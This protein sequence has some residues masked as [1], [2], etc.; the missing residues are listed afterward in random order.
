MGEQALAGKKERTMYRYR[1][2][3]VCSGWWVVVSAMGQ[4]G[5]WEEF[6][7]RGVEASSYF[8]RLCPTIM[9]SAKGRK[10][11]FGNA[12]QKDVCVLRM[13][14]SLL[15]ARSATCLCLRTYCICI[16]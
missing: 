13:R 15:A 12:S 2:R 9:G 8:V 10:R 3:K 6:G 5:R 11:F 14:C 1:D 16:E 7:G 4:G